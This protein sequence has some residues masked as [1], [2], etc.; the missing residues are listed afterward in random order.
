VANRVIQYLYNIKSRAI[1]YKRDKEA[2]NSKE[3]DKEIYNKGQDNRR[4]NRG[5]VQSFICTSNALFTDNSV[6]RKSLQGYIIKLFRE[7]I[8]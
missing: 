1:Y 7:L 8:T 3:R 2:I 5:E 6:N 4:D